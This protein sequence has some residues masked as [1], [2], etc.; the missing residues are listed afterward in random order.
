VGAISIEGIPFELADAAKFGKRLD[1]A[2][3]GASKAGLSPAQA[4]AIEIDEAVDASGGAVAIR[5]E[6][7]EIAFAVLDEWYPTAPESAR[8]LRR[9][10]GD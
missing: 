7:R 4:L 10:L 5:E 6:A 1:R 9:L 3:Y 8:Q 2:S